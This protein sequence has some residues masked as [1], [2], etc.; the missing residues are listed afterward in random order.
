[1]VSLH[2]RNTAARFL[3]DQVVDADDPVFSLR[4]GTG[5]CRMRDVIIGI[6]LR[7]GWGRRSGRDIG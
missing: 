7:Q 4:T 2:S 6:G 1:M 5:C 3:L